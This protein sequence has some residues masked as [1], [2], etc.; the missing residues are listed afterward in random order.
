LIGRDAHA[1]MI[2]REAAAETIINAALSL[3]RARVG[4]K[5]LILPRI[6]QISRATLPGTV[7]WGIG[8]IGMCLKCL[9]LGKVIHLG[10]RECTIQR[11]HQKL[12][13]ESPSPAID[14]KRRKE[15]A[16]KSSKP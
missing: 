15:W 11:R 4:S 10:E 1:A 12:V 5:A 2:A 7:F 8:I 3:I 14:P 16:R 6:E 13:E 9:R